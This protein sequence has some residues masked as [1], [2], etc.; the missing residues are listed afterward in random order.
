MTGTLPGFAAD[1]R[2]ILICRRRGCAWF[3]W[4]E[5]F[6]AR[7]FRASFC[8]W[9]SGIC[10]RQNRR[11][12]PPSTRRRYSRG[13]KLVR[14]MEDTMKQT[15]KLLFT[16]T[17]S[18]LVLFVSLNLSISARADLT[19]DCRTAADVITNYMQG[20]ANSAV[21]GNDIIQYPVGVA[22][23][24]FT[25]AALTKLALSQKTADE[26]QAFSDGTQFASIVSD[27]ASLSSDMDA[28]AH[29]DPTKAGALLKASK[30]IWDLFWIM[31]SRNGLQ[32]SGILPGGGTLTAFGA[33]NFVIGYQF[34][35]VGQVL[36]LELGV[37]DYGGGILNAGGEADDYA[38]RILAG[39]T[40][41]SS[42]EKAMLNDYFSWV[43]QGI[44]HPLQD[45]I[46]GQLDITGY[47]PKTNYNVLDVQA[48]Y[49]LLPPVLNDWK[50]WTIAADAKVVTN[51]AQKRLQIALWTYTRNSDILGDNSANGKQLPQV[52]LQYLTNG[53]WTTTNLLGTT[54]NIWGVTNNIAR[55]DVLYGPQCSYTAEIALP[56][57]C[58]LPSEV[59]TVWS[60]PGAPDT[61]NLT[62]FRFAD[63]QIQSPNHSGIFLTASTDSSRHVSIPV[64]ISSALAVTNLQWSLT[65]LNTTNNPPV[66]ATNLQVQFTGFPTSGLT[67]GQSVTGSLD[68]SFPANVPPGNYTGVL[69][70]D[71][72][73]ASP[74]ALAVSVNVLAGLSDGLVAYYPFDG[75]AND[76]SGNGNNASFIGTNYF[77]T[78]DSACTISNGTYIDAGNI[79]P[80]NPVTLTES[81]WI[82]STQQ[83]QPV[84]NGYLKHIVF[85]TRRTG[86]N[87]TQ[88]WFGGW[89]TLNI[90]D[91][92]FLA[93]TIDDDFY[94][95]NCQ[96]ANYTATSVFDGKWHQIVGIK[97]NALYSLYFDGEPISTIT[98]WHGLSASDGTEHFWI[99][100]H[101]WFYTAPQD[102]EDLN[103]S[104]RD[105]RIYNRALSA[106]EVAQLY[107]LSF[108]VLGA[109][110]QGGS[111]VFSWPTNLSGFTLV[112]ATNLGPSAVW[113]PVSPAPVVVNDQFLVTNSLSEP[114][115]FY[116]LKE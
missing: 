91:R 76:A 15:I 107:T 47:V 94:G 3:G 84:G 92:G 104:L 42:T 74:V 68:L 31:A 81:C 2:S 37:V 41:F 109:R 106:S 86:T 60:F 97:S 52:L 85:M 65:A 33:A 10:C 116:R 29:G 12:R 36:N 115:K 43:N 88:I 77:F 58:R 28:A 45:M 16:R 14:P 73:N 19:S 57:N 17:V 48:N 61:T 50:T 101:A 40:F 64:T 113:I 23:G 1:W 66:V 56:P 75:N 83:Q 54:T 110:L 34:F 67:N 25:E 62:V 90:N 46:N 49:G 44:Y 63:I 7:R 105:V 59:R 55:K 24:L 100:R 39:L 11:P 103:A 79:F 21:L 4:W 108:P 80:S 99:G 6:S 95:N 32:S 78:S 114:S 30:D 35:I 98:D 26:L 69:Q 20:M 53:V 13:K 87:A 93:L 22:Y 70:V 112:S 111:L 72:A 5:H 18:C 9:R 89:T 51:G 96:N 8:I 102:C 82:K 27:L 38:F 71:G